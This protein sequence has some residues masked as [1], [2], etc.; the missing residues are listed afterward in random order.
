M[1]L[2]VNTLL[3]FPTSFS[4]CFFDLP[5]LQ[6]GPTTS[7]SKIQPHLLAHQKQPQAIYNP[8]IKTGPVSI[9]NPSS[10]MTLSQYTTPSKMTP[11]H[12]QPPHQNWPCVNTQPLIKNDPKS[13]HNP[14][15]KNDPKPYTTP[16]SKLALCQYTTPH[17]K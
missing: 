17:Q 11:S 3:F 1:L 9:H 13:I 2:F 14:L 8:L 6:R 10:K 5:R 4:V 12:T 16:S 15:I 7:T